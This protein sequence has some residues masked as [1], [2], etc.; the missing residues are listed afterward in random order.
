MKKATILIIII[1]VVISAGCLI[2]IIHF[3]TEGIDKIYLNLANALFGVFLSVILVNVLIEKALDREKKWLEDLEKE[4]EEKQR[5][6]EI[7]KEKKEW[8][9]IYLY[10]S[11]K[12]IGTAIES[13]NILPPIYSFFIQNGIREPIAKMDRFLI[14]RSFDSF[15]EERQT[16]SLYLSRFIHRLEKHQIKD[17]RT[18][19]N[20]YTSIKKPDDMFWGTL[21]RRP[22]EMADIH[23]R[24]Q[25]RNYYD[26]VGKIMRM[27]EYYILQV[28]N[29]TL[30]QNI[31]K[32]VNDLELNDFLLKAGSHVGMLHLSD[33]KEYFEDYKNYGFDFSNTV[34]QFFL[35]KKYH[36]EFEKFFYHDIKTS[37]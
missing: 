21:L 29:N 11:E 36:N 10:L 15:Q 9:F 28:F 26:D 7:E 14:L 24:S 27:T 12:I 2:A 37:R 35:C 8:D 1:S 33:P 23:R 6:I 18:F 3:E 20:L 32:K 25:A 5:K 31:E 16:Y 34:A 17:Y 22:D 30:L 19:E 13:L 4:R